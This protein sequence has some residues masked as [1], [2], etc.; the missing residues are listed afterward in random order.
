LIEHT[1][2]LNTPQIGFEVVFLAASKIAGT[3]F[4]SPWTILTL[5]ASSFFAELEALL[6]VT[7]RTV[8]SDACGEERMESTT[9]PPCFPVAPVTRI[10]LDMARRRIDRLIDKFGRWG[11]ILM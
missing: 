3:S 2:T 6:R 11:P 1:C 9:A 8:N 10:T 5:L 4:I 7:A